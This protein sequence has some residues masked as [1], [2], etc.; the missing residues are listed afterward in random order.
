MPLWLV[1]AGEDERRRIEAILRSEPGRVPAA[2]WTRATWRT[3]LT[4]LLQPD[5]PH[6]AVEAV[7][8]HGDTALIRGWALTPRK[9]A[10]KDF[11][12]AVDER[13]VAVASLVKTPRCDVIARFP[14]ASAHCGF[15]LRI[16]W[17]DPSRTGQPQGPLTVTARYAPNRS[18]AL[19]AA[20]TT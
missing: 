9:E 14:H 19:P 13:P 12:V 1:T 10:A 7:E 3:R 8:I 11:A 4:A 2:G 15:N 18:F 5:G 16:A 17:P 20:G 6:G